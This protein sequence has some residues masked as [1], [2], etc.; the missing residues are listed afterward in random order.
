MRTIFLMLALCVNHLALALPHQEPRASL[1]VAAHS[2]NASD[3]AGLDVRLGGM[4]LPSLQVGTT[5]DLSPALDQLDFEMSTRRFRYD[6]PSSL[7]S[8]GN[9]GGF[10][11]A[12]SVSFGQYFSFGRYR[13]G[14]RLQQHPLLEML[15]PRSAALASASLLSVPGEFMTKFLILEREVI[16]AGFSLTPLMVGLNR[17][18]T[19]YEGGAFLEYE[20]RGS[21]RFSFRAYYETRSLDLASRTQSEVEIGTS[22]RFGLPGT[23]ELPIPPDE[24]D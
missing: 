3:A 14:L 16:Q 23:E 20:R 19:G 2:L 7:D 18:G 24:L 17:S 1:G 10:F 22:L 6:L 9:N 5:F 13:I 15:S 4:V 21:L 12:G 8:L 11:F